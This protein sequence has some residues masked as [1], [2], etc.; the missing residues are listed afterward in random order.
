MIG[1]RTAA[2]AAQ[3]IADALEHAG[4]AYAIG[5]A[6]A[7]GVA[8]VPR[9]TKDVDVNVFVGEA[10]WAAVVGALSSLGIL[11]DVDEAIAHAKRDGMFIGM[12]DGMRI[13][14]FVPSIPFADE[15]ART[16]VTVTV[17]GW[18]GRFLSPEAISIFKLLF[19]R[20]KDRSDLERLVA[21]RADKLDHAYVRRWMVEMMG[22]N[23]ERVRAWDEIV[24][25]YGPPG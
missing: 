24:T 14:V 19:F 20:L 3:Q 8:G 15:A 1:Q 9:G 25:R 16:A 13:D 6:L 11:I 4:H 22:E 2:E 21:V 18:T 23:D 12:W 7:L 17:D 5:G 10:D